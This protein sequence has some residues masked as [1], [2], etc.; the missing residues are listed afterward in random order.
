MEQDKSEV[1]DGILRI[2]KCESDLF[3]LLLKVINTIATLYDKLAV[4]FKNFVLS[5]AFVIHF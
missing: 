3:R 4:C 2:L 5:A 1:F